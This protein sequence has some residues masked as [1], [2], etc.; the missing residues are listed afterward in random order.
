MFT[1]AICDDDYNICSQL[2]YMIKDILIKLGL[3]ANIDIFYSGKKLKQK[4]INGSI[5]DLLL[6][7]IELDSI[8]GMDIGEL[9]R[10]DLRLESVNIVYISGQPKYVR[11]LFRTRPLE[12]LDKPINMKHLEE[13]FVRAVKLWERNKTIFEY[14]TGKIHNRV[15]YEDISYFESDDK[16]I[17][18]HLIGDKEDQKF[19]GKLDD[20]KKQLTIDFIKIHKSYIINYYNMKTVGYES[21]ETIDGKILSISQSRR[22]KVRKKVFLIRKKEDE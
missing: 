19:Y 1:I 21:V 7:D 2:E 3:R 4:I 11:E 15:R 14:K 9:I 16:K 18:I 12:F 22:Q 17:I 13:V 20:I 5:Y 6:L 8:K 10:E